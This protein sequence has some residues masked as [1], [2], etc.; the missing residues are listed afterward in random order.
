MVDI[1]KDFSLKS[2]LRDMCYGKFQFSFV[3]TCVCVC[4]CYS[5]L[6]FFSG[7]QKVI[8]FMCLS[9][10]YYFFLSFFKDCIVAIE[11]L[12]K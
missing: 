10:N 12:Q 11:K 2:S 6:L 9:C 1:A 3:C 4:L 8:V 7:E 5:R